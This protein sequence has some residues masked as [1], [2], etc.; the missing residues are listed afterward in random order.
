MRLSTRHS[1]KITPT[2]SS[3]EMALPPIPVGSLNPQKMLVP[4]DFTECSIKAVTYA[5]SLAKHFGSEIILLHVAPL[6]APT[7]SAELVA[8]QGVMIDEQV[9]EDAAKHLTQW[10]DRI[11]AHVP[12]RAL[13]SNGVSIQD[14]IVTTA[15]RYK[16]DLI[17]IATHALGGLAHF[18]TG[19]VT[20]KVVH[21]APC[22][23][24]VVREREHDFIHSRAPRRGRRTLV[25]T[26]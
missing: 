21:H 26:R 20:E 4:V 2:L 8:L 7:P 18:L 23:V 14:E 17:I 6:A 22:P 25:A 24:F 16:C 1:R 10:R 19:S 13:V 3:D 9:R 5:V 15:R 11:A 12:A